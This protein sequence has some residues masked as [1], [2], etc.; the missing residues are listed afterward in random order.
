MREGEMRDDDEIIAAYEHELETEEW[1][2]E[3]DPTPETRPPVG[4]GFWIVSISLMLAC[5]LLVVAIFVNFPLKE[6]VG[7]AQS[8]L[9]KA[10]FAAEDVLELTGSFVGA[11]AEG[12]AEQESSLDFREAN[13]P[14]AGLDSVS[15]HATTSVWAAAVQAEPGACFYLRLDRGRQDEKFGVGT[16]CTGTAALGASDSRW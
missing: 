14:S 1:I 8:S 4:R 15:V 3:A 13:E 5:L 6:E 12:L 10:Q 9:R 16:V 2:V 7:H 11:D